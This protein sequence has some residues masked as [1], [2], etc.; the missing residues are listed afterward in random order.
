MKLTMGSSPHIRTPQ[1]SGDLMGHVVL[2]LL[3]ALAVGVW[4]LGASALWVA[5]VCTFTSV[6]TEW[7]C[8]GGKMAPDGSVA[9][10]GLLLA[11]T[12]PPSLPLW[13]WRWARCSG[14]D[15]DKSSSIRRWWLV[16]PCCCVFPAP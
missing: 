10:T 11:M 1:R 9:V 7:L 13:P 14:A 3:P 16:P 15:W 4:Q 8:R 5:L 6:V 12:L 2:A